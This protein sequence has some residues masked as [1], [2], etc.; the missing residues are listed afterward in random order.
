MKEHLDE[1]PQ[2]KPLLRKRNILILF[3]GVLALAVASFFLWKHL[4][5]K[6]TQE[7]VWSLNSEQ[8]AQDSPRM[9]GL[10]NLGNTCFLNSLIQMLYH[11]SPFRRHLYK[12]DEATAS[13]FALA[14]LRTFKTM[15]TIGKGPLQ[16]SDIDL[17]NLLPEG[18]NDGGQHEV[19]KLFQSWSEMEEDSVVFEPFSFAIQTLEV[20]EYSYGEPVNLVLYPEFKG[21]Y[22]NPFRAPNFNIAQ[23]LKQTTS[24]SNLMKSREIKYKYVRTPEALLVCIEEPTKDVPKDTP[25]VVDEFLT[26]E[27]IEV[28][29]N[30][31][32]FKV[33]GKPVR[34]QLRAFIQHPSPATVSGHF[35]AFA[36]NDQNKWFRLD[37]ALVTEA[38][39]FSDI[40]GRAEL[41]SFFVYERI[42]E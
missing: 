10:R 22:R 27:E 18:F 16:R 26:V 31:A 5:T 29:K 37:D 19:N 1:T 28:A 34:Y 8:V 21:K 6:D 35:I 17:D 11:C 36:R 13:P 30:V 14:L 2:E 7:K 9:I 25:I 12:S 33:P 23:C 24:S 3:A 4:S 32:E 42:D 20:V 40:V 38:G 15:D 39:S 41:S